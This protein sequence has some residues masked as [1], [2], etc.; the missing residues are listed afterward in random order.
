MAGLITDYTSLQ[1]A[2]VEYLA[3]DQDATL[4]ARVPAFVQLFESKMN[5]TLFVRQMETR[6]TA[7]TDPTAGEPEF[8]ALPADFQ[9]MRR[10]RLASVTGKPLLEFK[11]T[12]Q[13]D[14]FRAQTANQAG[15]PRYFTIFGN[16]IELAPTPEAIYT[17][18]MVYRQNVPALADNT[19]NWLLAIA[20]DLYL[21][22]SLMESA[23]Y[24]KEDARIQ[25]WGALLISAL[26]DL[27]ELGKVSA[28]NAGPMTVR[29]A[30]NNIW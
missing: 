22:G 10:I 19:T 21:Y 23:P 14:E 8:I 25:T 4:T 9:S 26:T 11:S 17:V 6:A 18:E 1:A 7:L 3:R 28:F 2:I 5:R 24:I 15:Q 27:N 30:G 20:P 29:P 16:E 12:A 13:M